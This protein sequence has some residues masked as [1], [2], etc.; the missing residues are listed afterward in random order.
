ME[1]YVPGLDHGP[2]IPRTRV[3]PRDLLLSALGVVALAATAWFALSTAPAEA[4]EHALEPE[5]GTS[6]A[7]IRPEPVVA[8][9]VFQKSSANS[10]TSVS[11]TSV[12]AVEAPARKNAEALALEAGIIRGHVSLSTSVLDRLDAVTITIVEA[13]NLLP[14]SGN[15]SGSNVAPVQKRA[16]FTTSRMLAVAKHKGTPT[17][18]IEGVPFSPYGYTVYAIAPGLNGTELH[19]VVTKDHP[20]ADVVLGITGGTPFSVLVRD[21][22]QIPLPNV[23]VTLMPSGTPLGRPMLQKPTDTFGSVLFESVLRGP[24]KVHAGPLYAQLCDPK[25]QDVLAESGHVA[26]SLVMVVPRGNDLPVQV[27]GPSGAGL[28]DVAIEAYAT[29]TQ[30]FRKYEGKTDYSGQFTFKHL[31]AGNYQVTI[32]AEAYDHFARTWQVPET[33]PSKALIARLVP[34]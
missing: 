6:P 17:F 2:R 4:A 18:T 9:G 33:E 14:A 20:I 29:D 16:P 5:T 23:L 3:K 28:A 12:L 8:D 19:A 26:Q 13:I 7:P 1:Y 10:D 24:Y 32:K 15:A 31:P 34:Q 30:Q 21:Q 27:F 11:D 25:D 22:Q